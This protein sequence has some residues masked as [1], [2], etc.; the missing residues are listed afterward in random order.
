MLLKL[1]VGGVSE[2]VQVTGAARVVDTTSTTI[3]AVINT[4]DLKSIP[5]GRTFSATM[6]LS[7][8]VSSSGTL[9][10][11]EPVDVRCLRPREPVRR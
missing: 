3:G 8:G 7:A 6:Y 9:G 5:I 1:E 4:D 10:H 11:R 2:V